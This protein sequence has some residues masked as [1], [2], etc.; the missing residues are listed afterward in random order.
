ME[1]ALVDLGIQYQNIK[2]EIDQAIADTLAQTAFIGGS[3]VSQFEQEFA[4]YL[5][6]NH[7]ISCGNG[8]DSLEILLEVFGVGEGDEVLVPALSWISTSEVVAT[9][10]ATPVFVDVDPATYVIDP[11]QM[12][13][14]ITSRT[15][16]IIPV[17]LYGHPADMP[18]IMEIAQKHDL[19]VIEDCAQAHGAK[20]NDK[21]IGT[22]GHAA[23][24]SFFPSKNLGCFGDGGA[25]VVPD[26]H[27]ADQARMIAR[28]GQKTRHDHRVHGRN[29]RLDALQA[30]ILSVKLPHLENWT[31][32]RI[33]HA[34]RYRELLSE[35][36]EVHTPTTHSDCRHVFHVYVI[37]ASK[38][39]ALKD[40]LAEHGVQ[41]VVHYPVALPFQP[42]YDDLN[43][44]EEDFPI[45][46]QYQDEVLSL[47]MYPELTEEAI[48]KV[49]DTVKQFYAR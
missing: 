33:Q 24:F 6:D 30:A 42:C 20:I 1:I 9:R 4:Q 10:G 38:R 39:D 47:P 13:A 14:K 32:L 8:T 11:A 27:L 23:S 17:H 40:Y 2:S 18:K 21:L 25:M 3:R 5:G 45:A 15:R 41:S 22:W 43:I 46:R 16:A 48:R 26:E 12:E 7:V 44:R 28:H 49:T 36:E 29:S 37:R 19:K 31:E 34:Q 35:V